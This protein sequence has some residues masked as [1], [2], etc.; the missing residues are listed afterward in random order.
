MTP[1]VWLFDLDNTLHDAG[2]WVFAQMNDTMRNYVVDALRVTPAQADDL[3]DKYWRRYGSTMLGLVRHH[4]V[5]PAHFLHETHRFPGLEQRVTGHRHDLAA[6][7]RLRG[8]RVLLTNAPRAYALRVLGALGIVQLF[9]EVLA[10]EDM[11]MFGHWRPKPDTRMLRHVA[12]RLGVHPSRCV[13]VEDSLDNVLA[14]R[15][16]GMTP[17]WMQRFARRGT[18]AGPRVRRWSVHPSGVRIVRNLRSLA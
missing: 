7:A 12:A 14:A 13:L 15:R 2:A 17:V 16:V 5:S 8:R 3:R 18:H 6:V 11:R 9:D 10:I 1:R 4:A